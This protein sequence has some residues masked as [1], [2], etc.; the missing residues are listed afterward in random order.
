MKSDTIL[1]YPASLCI[2]LCL[3]LPF[4]S[5]PIYAQQ[6]S[7]SNTA[8]TGSAQT[9]SAQTG[10]AEAS[11]REIIQYGTETEISSLI[12]SL[13]TERADYLD[14]DLIALAETSR[15]MKVLTG[16][17]GFFAE[18]DKSGLE[19]RA[20]RAIREREE[21]AN[22]TIQSAMEYLGKLKVTQAAS[23]IMELLDTEERRFLATGFRTLGLT[24]S[25]DKALS[26]ETA[27][28]LI[29]YYEYRDPGNDNRSTLINAI[30]A[31]GSS[32]AVNF[33]V[34]IA[35]NTDERIPLRMAA[36]DALSKI[37]DPDGLEAILGCINTNDPNV[38]S[39]AVAALGP[40]SGPSVEKAIFDGFRD[41]YYRTRIAAA[42][43]SRER[44]LA[45]AVPYLKFRAE[46]DEVPNV[47]DEAIRALGAIANNEA[48]ETLNN[49]FTDRR[50]TDR[51]RIL[52]A[53]MLFKN[54]TGR[55]I[56]ALVIELEEAKTKN[57]TG[58]YN[59]LLKVIG[60]T[61]V[62]GDKT[63]IENLARRF[64]QNGTIIEK[65]Y[66]L[67]IASNNNL[68]GLS[69]HI[70]TLTKDRNTSLAQKARRVANVLDIVLPEE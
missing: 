38:R 57:Q 21:E 17:F 35:S 24:S 59:G 52:S 40:F 61:L 55:N 32:A 15:N 42:Q 16:V 3:I 11:R 33:L 60:E 12:Q 43:A 1:I 14:N 63:E 45:S 25:G 4:L 68:R 51:V 53:E 30:G 47:K 37:G 48:L 18:R 46:R 29:D 36:L 22:E 39:A 19:T 64:M 70:I 5:L 28:F 67:D 10:S 69:E 27:E 44:R 23:V 2:T 66:G 58:L 50:N 49:L 62:E 26:D 13:R 20:I 65:S 34:G 8:Q 31:T 7:A 41:S 54:N 6:A 9:G 56:S